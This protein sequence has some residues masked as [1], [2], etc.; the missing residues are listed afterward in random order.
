MKFLRHLSLKSR[1][2]LGIMTVLLPLF[3]TF[4]TYEIY[5]TYRRNQRALRSKVEQIALLTLRQAQAQLIFEDGELAGELLQYEHFPAIRYAALL[6]TRQQPINTYGEAPYV[7]EVEGTMAVSAFKNGYLEYYQ[8][9][10]FEQ[11]A[12]GG[13]L[14]VVDAEEVQHHTRIELQELGLLL[15]LATLLVVVLATVFQ[16]LVSKPLRTLSDFTREVTDRQ[17]YHKRLSLQ[18]QDP[19]VRLLYRHINTLLTT[20]ESTMVSRGYLDTLLRSMAEMLIVLDSD[21]LIQKVNP[22]VTQ[23]L[24]YRQEELIGQRLDLLLK[25][26]TTDDYYQQ[27]QYETAFY[28]KAGTRLQVLVSLS[29]VIAAH[30]EPMA[31]LICTAR[32]MTTEHEARQQ[33]SMHLDQLQSAQAQLQ[34][35]KEVAEHSLKIKS[36]FLSK[37][38]HEIRTPMNAIMGLAHL[39]LDQATTPTQATELKR[40]LMVS[41][42]LQ[43]LINDILDYSHIESGNVV[44]QYRPFSLHQLLQQIQS[45]HAAPHLDLYLQVDPKVPQHVVGD[46]K[47]LAQVLHHLV[48]NAV[49]FTAQGHVLIAVTPQ[50]TYQQEVWLQFVVQD[51]GIGIPSD[52]LQ[53]IFD[54]FTQVDNSLSR[55]Y[56]GK[57]LGLSIVKQLL[58]LQGSEIH[59]S[60]TVGE[61][62]RFSFILRLRHVPSTDSPAPEATAM[63]SAATP[64]TRPPR[65]LLVEDNH[66]NIIVTRKLLERWNMEVTVA[67]N[68]LL[69]VEAAQKQQ[70]DLILMDLQMPV[71]NGF[72]ATLA[73]RRLANYAQVPIIAL[74]A[75]VL[76]DAENQARTVGMQDFVAKP[77]KP[78]VLQQAMAQYLGSIDA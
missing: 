66:M 8:P 1:L 59:V 2:T 30:D 24:G 7:V 45:R 38:S 20:I 9:A 32:D 48:H 6:N 25:R 39:L 64:M 15:S 77:F 65:I 62:T 72:E 28:T 33:L 5:S 31:T 54:S 47:R 49:R 17:V 74:T 43:Q 42:G 61:G 71:M 76:E 60:S 57:G 35:A 44:F 13:L 78:A 67:E 22:A 50:Q 16:Q 41:E 26:V 4:L 11:R 27:G 19:E 68:G 69:S 18:G 53:T 23:Q 36:E 40:L 12:I 46:E 3:L 58:Q 73:I 21:F 56:Q 37:M 51:T 63:R 34:K 55:E 29:E 52:K 75:E 14:L 70:F 10:Y